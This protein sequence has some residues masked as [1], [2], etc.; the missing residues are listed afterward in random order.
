MSI[1][2]SDDDV[3][4]TCSL[5]LLFAWLAFGLGSLDES[6][7]SETFWAPGEEHGRGLQARRHHSA[8]GLSGLAAWNVQEG[9]TRAF[10][11]P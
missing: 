6:R 8:R 4:S 9:G 1:S 7:D 10:A 11:V 5:Q 3:S 2:S